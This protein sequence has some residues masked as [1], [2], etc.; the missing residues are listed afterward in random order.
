[1]FVSSSKRCFFT[2]VG[3][4]YLNSTAGNIQLIN[5]FRNREYDMSE[6]PEERLFAFW[7]EFFIDATRKEFLSTQFPVSHVTYVVACFMNVSHA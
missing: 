4:R 3:C 5:S 1:M 2:A 7:M 6:K